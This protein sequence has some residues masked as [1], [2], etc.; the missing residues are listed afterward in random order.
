MT[1]LRIAPI[2][3]GYGEVSAVPELLRRIGAELLGGLYIDVLKPIRQP[4]SKPLRY[5]SVTD[6]VVPDDDSIGRA[7]KLASK[8]L[9]QKREPGESPAEMILLLLD[10][11]SDCAKRL[12][13]EIRD[14]ITRA[15][16]TQTGVSV[17]LPVVEYET[18]FVAAANSIRD[19][20][21]VE[22]ADIPANPAAD[23]IGKAWI[24]RTFRGHYSETIDQVRLT[25][26]MDFVACRS[27]ARSFDKLCR[28]LERYAMNVENST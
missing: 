24:E 27:Q 7:A 9:A 19:F 21:N 28:E 26:K 14:A 4:R 5:C 13:P 12:A 2:V 25:A 3:E 1:P 15:A 10:S 20:L 8:K 6:E 23:C 18:W 11:N 22:D 17:V 16:G